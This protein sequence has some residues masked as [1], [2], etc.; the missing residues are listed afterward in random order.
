VI[1]NQSINQIYSPHT[2]HKQ[3]NK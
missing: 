3:N 2:H 1:D